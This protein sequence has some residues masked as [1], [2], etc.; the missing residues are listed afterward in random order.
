MSLKLEA[1]VVRT[2]G[3]A[4][5][6]GVC[7]SNEI[8]SASTMGIYTPCARWGGLWDSDTSIRVEPVWHH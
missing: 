2:D 5:L 4:R 3:S 6:A 8:L 7:A 1:D